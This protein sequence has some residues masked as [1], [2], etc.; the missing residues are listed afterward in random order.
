MFIARND[1][2][3]G[4]FKYGNS[5]YTVFLPSQMYLYLITNSHTKFMSKDSF[6]PMSELVNMPIEILI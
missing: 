6:S 3:Y 1:Q 4:V 5:T 2:M